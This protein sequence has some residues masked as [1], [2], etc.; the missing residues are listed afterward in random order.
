MSFFFLFFF[1]LCV[2]YMFFKHIEIM[3]CNIREEQRWR[4][5]HREMDSIKQ[6]PSAMLLRA[7]IVLELGFSLSGVQRNLLCSL[8]P[9]YYM[10]NN[11]NCSH[12]YRF[13]MYFSNFIFYVQFIFFWSLLWWNPLHTILFYFWFPCPLFSSAFPLSSTL[14]SDLSLSLGALPFPPVIFVFLADSLACLTH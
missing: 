6:T 13:L 5:E 4:N 14:Y 7:V 9:A 1:F 12:C 10:C 8:P 3:K 11:V 2:R